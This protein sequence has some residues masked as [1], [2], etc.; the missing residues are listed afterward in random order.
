MLKKIL[1]T[2]ADYTLAFARIILGIVYFPHGAQKVLGWFGGH[3]FSAVFA[4]LAICAEFFGAIGL[5]LG[6]LGRVA[7]FGLLCEMCVAVLAIHRHF[8]FFMN[9]AGNQRGEG[10]E[11]HLL[12][13]ALLVVV[14]VKGSGALSL[15]RL[16]AGGESPDWSAAPTRA[17]S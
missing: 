6:L 15:D 16:L 7:A 2:D 1:R 4:F 3:G 10:F 13:I 12:A 11:Y 8:G 9:W 14:L 17:G 5:I